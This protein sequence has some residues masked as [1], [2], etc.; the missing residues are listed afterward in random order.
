MAASSAPSNWRC[1]SCCDDPPLPLAA[2]AL[3]PERL[4]GRSVAEI[5]HLA[6][7][8]GK[9]RAAIGDWFRV[10]ATE[11]DA[12]EIDGPSGRLDRI[13]AGMSVG[14]IAIH[15]DAGAYLGIG[16]SGGSIAVAGSAGFGAATDLRGGTLRVAG[17]VGDGLGGPLPGAS[18]GM[19]DGVVIVAGQAGEA[20]GAALRRG[21]VVI[22]GDVGDGC[23]AE[24]IAGTIMVGGAVGAHAG[25]AMRHGSIVALGGA[26]GIGVGFVDCGIHD[27][28]WLRVLSRHLAALGASELARRLGP[29]RRFAGDAAVA[30]NGEL[31][32]AP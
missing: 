27:L 28:V 24:M 15:G 16:M 7:A 3:V 23:G 22:G 20:A 4:A 14:S 25:A 26:M 21:L 11:D 6:L 2:D 9:T 19:R 18:G 8:V 12:I 32:I 29:L 1:T 13:G 17:N 5:E 31:L 30:G 10:A